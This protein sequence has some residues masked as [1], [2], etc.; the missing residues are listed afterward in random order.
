MV[1]G[2]A[3]QLAVGMNLSSIQGRCCSACLQA[4]RDAADAAGLATMVFTLLYVHLNLCAAYSDACQFA[5][6]LMSEFS[7]HLG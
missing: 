5:A 7:M 1:C 6:R 3:C 2:D 4:C